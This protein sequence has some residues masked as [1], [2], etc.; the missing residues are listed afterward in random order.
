MSVI[1]S[2]SL[3]PN[4]IT[5]ARLL[6]VPVTVYLLLKSSYTA[7]FW[8]FAAAG[9]SDALDGYLAKRLGVQ[10]E[11]G[12]YM[13]PLADK[14]LIVGVFITLGYIGHVPL[15]LVLL[16]AFRDL[17]IIGG[18]LLFQTLTQSLKM[19]PLMISKLNT[20]A[21]I[22]LASVLLAELGL[23]LALPYLSAGLTYVVAAT[24]FVSG[25]AYVVKW[26]WLA[27]TLERSDR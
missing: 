23:G 18:A 17:L 25:T 20:V 7:A 12:A 26:G 22:A 9:L 3:L 27:I 16:I 15:W 2:L 4:L 6:A 24:T 14:A 11:I 13:D 19:A 10:S 21:Q 5:L 1:G 8:V